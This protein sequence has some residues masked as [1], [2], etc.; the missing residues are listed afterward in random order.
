MKRY[1]LKLPQ[2]SLLL[3]P[4]ARLCCACRS[5]CANVWLFDDYYL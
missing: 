5:D 2:C 4:I 1:C 3:D